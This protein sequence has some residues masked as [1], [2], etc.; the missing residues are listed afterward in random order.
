VPKS[1]IVLGAGA[2]G[3]E[4]ASIFNHVGSKTTL[5]EFMPRVLPIE[6]EDASKEL[7]KHFSRRKDKIEVLT[8]TKVEKVEPTKNGIRVLAT[9]GTE[10]VTLE[11]EVLLSAVGRAPV[12]NDF[13]MQHTNIKLE[14]NGTI[15]VDA[16]MRTTEPGV[17]AIGDIVPHAML[18]HVASAQ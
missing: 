4:F 1:I 2:V 13:G 10:Q 6:D 7:E 14:K 18:A 16:M 17:F 9:K 5:V 11:A 15:K 3:C 8:S 12:T